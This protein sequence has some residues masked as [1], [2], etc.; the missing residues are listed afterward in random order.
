VRVCLLVAV[1]H[2]GCWLVVVAAA[3]GVTPRIVQVDILAKV[4]SSQEVPKKSS[5]EK[6]W[7]AIQHVFLHRISMR[8]LL[9]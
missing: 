9:A 6:R 5:L 2:A 8:V 3:I 7:G 4:L 1:G